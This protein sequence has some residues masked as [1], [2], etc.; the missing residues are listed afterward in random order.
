MI[1]SLAL[2]TTPSLRRVKKPLIGVRYHFKPISSLPEVEVGFN[3]VDPSSATDQVGSM[4]DI[5]G[6]LIS[7]AGDEIWRR[8]IHLVDDSEASV[9]VTLWGDQ[10]RAQT[11]GGKPF[12]SG[13]QF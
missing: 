4:V 3:E 9:S 12:D 8:I 7:Q 11:V 6:V 13:N 2:M 1:S 10:V 5:I